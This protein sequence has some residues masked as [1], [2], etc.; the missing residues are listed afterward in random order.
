MAA[1]SLDDYIDSVANA[2]GLPVEDAWRR[3]R[4]GPQSGKEREGTPAPVG[5][6]ALEAL[7]FDAPAADR[8]H[9][10]LDPGFVDEDQAFWIEMT[11]RPLP[12]GATTHDVGA[13][14]LTGKRGFF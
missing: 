1:D 6:E 9:V 10:G 13:M 7:A 8:C 5:S 2:L 11:D 12:A 4:I 3:E 14:L